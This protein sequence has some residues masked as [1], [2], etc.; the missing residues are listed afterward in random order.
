MLDLQIEH[1]FSLTFVW[2]PRDLN[3]CAD[4]LLHVSEM[5]HHHYSLSE[6]WF[7]YL[8][9]LWGPHTIDLFA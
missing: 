4:F 8:D 2:V 6:E 9:W 5:L 1:R 7:A 3:V